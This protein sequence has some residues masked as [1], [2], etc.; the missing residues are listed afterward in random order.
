MSFPSEI[1][2]VFAEIKEEV[3]WVHGRWIIY[4]QL[5]LHSDKRIDLLN[6]VASAFFY[7]IQNLLL[8]EVQITLSKFTDPARSGKNENLS[9][10]QLQERV[11]EVGNPELSVKLRSVLNQLQDTCRSCRVWRNKQLAHLDLD[12]SLKLLPDALPAVTIEQIDAALEITREYLNLLERFYTESETG[13]EHFIMHSDGD[14]LVEM[15]KLG[16]RY[17]ELRKLDKFSW[18]DLRESPWHDA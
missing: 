11:E 16:L 12:T 3:I 6:D 2:E 18:D 14:A 8:E 5:F 7:M 13:Y 1:E 15:L 4:R 10:E 17:D 9:L